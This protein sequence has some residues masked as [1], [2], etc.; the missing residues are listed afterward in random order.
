MGIEGGWWT[1]TPETEYETCPECGGT[2]KENITLD[3]E[4]YLCNGLGRIKKKNS[5]DDD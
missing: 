5:E 4:C 2:G 1:F 3:S